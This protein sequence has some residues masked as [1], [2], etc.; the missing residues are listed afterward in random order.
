MKTLIVLLGPTGVGKTEL[1]LKLAEWMGSPILSADSRQLYKDLTI[2]TAAPTV[3]QRERIIH[4]FVGTL[5]LPDYYSASQFEQDVMALCKK[6]FL[7]H[8]SILM[9]GGS[10]MYIDAVTKGI[11]D[12][13]SVHPEIRETVWQEYEKKGL[14]PFV[15]ELKNKDPLHYEEVDLNNY[16]RVIHAIEI[17]RQTG[18]PYSFF[19]T[20]KQKERP[21][22][23][24]Q[25]GL[26]REREELYDRINQRVDQMIT[27]GLVEEAKRV[28]PYHQYNSLNT[29]GYKEL[30]SYFNGEWPLNAAIEKIKRNSRVYARKQMTWF[31][32]DKGIEWFHPKQE[33]EIK[34]YILSR[35]D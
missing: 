7:T 3:Q 14:A 8:D 1:S 25:V 33:E 12:I 20:K 22:K 19:R 11:D 15:E 24:I 35:Q 28:Y 2:G 27:D 30:F 32:R 5:E 13:P 26:T 9:T 16:K 10:M 18:L 31:K 29:V 23:I 17:C 6:L 34:Q 4:Y 21:F